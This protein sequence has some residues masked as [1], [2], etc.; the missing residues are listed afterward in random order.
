MSL[1]K[2]G[3]N[4]HTLSRAGRLKKIEEL[5]GNDNFE[6]QQELICLKA[7]ITERKGPFGFTGLHEAI[8]GDSLETLKYLFTH[9]DQS[10]VNIKADGRFSLLHLAASNGSVR[11]AKYL[12]EN[13]AQV[14]AEDE[15]GKT[16]KRTAELS[17]KRR[18]VN[19]FN[20]I[21]IYYILL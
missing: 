6:H 16:P 18:V 2:K 11:I 19:Y 15:Y 12:V 21:G 14:D 8:A 13:G 7:Q 20:G 1:W 17:S 5:F 10:E 4:L 3:P 9:V